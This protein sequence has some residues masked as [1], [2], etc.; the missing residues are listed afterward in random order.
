[1]NAFKLINEAYS[2]LGDA[3][4]RRDYDHERFSRASTLRAR[5][6]G[7]YASELPVEGPKSIYE[8]GPEWQTMRG[9]AATSRGVASSAPSSSSSSGGAVAGGAASF[10]GYSAEDNEEAF[11]RS[12]TR[13]TERQKETARFRAS[14]ARMNRPKLDIPSRSSS[15][16]KLAMPLGVVGLW[17]FNYFVFMR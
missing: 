3:A 2:V 6:E 13:A 7:I 14:Y 16:M 4:L 1:M 12:M 9:S 8:V 10:S 11:R 17:V 5:N 15:L